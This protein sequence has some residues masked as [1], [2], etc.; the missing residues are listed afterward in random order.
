[1]SELGGVFP[2]YYGEQRFGYR[3]TN[4]D[5]GLYMLKGD[6]KG[7]ALN[8][9]TE[10]QNETMDDAREARKRLS[11]E[12]DFRAALDYFPRYLKYERSMIEYLSKYPTNYANAIRKLPRS[13]SL[14]F[15]HSVE[16]QI[17]NWELD[18]RIKEGS[19]LPNA[20]D[21]V[22]Y[23]NTY[24]FP[25]IST[26]ERFDGSKGKRAFSVGNIIGQDTKN[27]TDFERNKLEEF[28]ITTDS[29]K[30]NG[31]DELHSTGT[32][33]ALFAPF[34]DIN[35]AHEE[36]GNLLKIGFSLPAGSYATVFLDE[37]VAQNAE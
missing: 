2:N 28:G 23:E 1:V 16:A 18:E 15:I 24:G 26:I 3:K 11:E 33:R 5:I 10:T 13:I 17:F 30:V 21:F 22:C 27:I 14:M 12:L 37:L 32:S 35:Y 6:F 36:D 9:L 25:D 31:L 8:F 7:A 20:S 19:V 34:R 29:F 4:F